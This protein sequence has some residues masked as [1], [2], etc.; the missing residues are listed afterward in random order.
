MEKL[1]VLIPDID[2][3]GRYS[4]LSLSNVFRR[5]RGDRRTLGIDD[6]PLFRFLLLELKLRLVHDNW[7]RSEMIK[8]LKC[9]DF[10]KEE[11]PKEFEK[12]LSK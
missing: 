8:A 1:E 10:Y 2:T 7:D 12:Y 6:Y 5:F 11:I 4:R 3:I 9:T